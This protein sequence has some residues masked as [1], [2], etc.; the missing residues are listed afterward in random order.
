LL[1]NL[2]LFE[3]LADLFRSKCANAVETKTKHHPILFSETNV[4]GGELGGHCT[5]IPRMSQRDSRTNQ[6][7]V[8]PTRSLLKIEEE[9]SAAKESSVTI[10]QKC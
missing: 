6:G 4:E 9:G 8:T 3:L 5:T 10:S 7:T 2:K 1:R